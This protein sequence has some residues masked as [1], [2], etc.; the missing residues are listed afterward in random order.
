MASTFG[1][2]FDKILHML[3]RDF[4]PN[5][6]LPVRVRSVPGLKLDGQSVWAY[7]EF[8]PGKCWVI[9]IHRSASREM[10]CEILIHEWAHVLKDERHGASDDHD[11][12]HS[13][14]WGVI[15]AR[16]YRASFNGGPNGKDHPRTD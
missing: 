13:D 3:R 8:N 6:G 14:E 5:C 4:A 7:A 9:K 1:A 16:L 15:Y 12:Q 11:V 2:K 10:A